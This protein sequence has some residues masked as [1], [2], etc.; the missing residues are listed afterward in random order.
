MLFPRSS[1]FRFLIIVMRKIKSTPTI[2]RELLNR[3]YCDFGSRG[4]DRLA[5]RQEVKNRLIVHGKKPME[6]FD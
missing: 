2:I 5:A 4:D 6:I 1:C 3:N